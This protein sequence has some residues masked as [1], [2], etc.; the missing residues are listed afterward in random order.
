MTLAKLGVAPDICSFFGFWLTP[1]SSYSCTSTSSRE[2]ESS[3]PAGWGSAVFGFS[4]LT[5]IDPDSS[6][7]LNRFSMGCSWIMSCEM[8]SDLA[9]EIFSESC[10]SIVSKLLLYS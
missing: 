7:C 9:G 5:L 10:L 2:S 6:V 3:H 4:G 1:C 8:G